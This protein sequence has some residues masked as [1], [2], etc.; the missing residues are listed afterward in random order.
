VKLVQFTARLE[1]GESTT[2]ESGANISGAAQAFP[3]T[4]LPIP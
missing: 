1:N 2:R 3:K 4:S